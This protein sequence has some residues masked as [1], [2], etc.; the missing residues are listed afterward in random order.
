MLYDYLPER[1]ILYFGD[2]KYVVE[3]NNGK[4]YILQRYASEK[5]IYSGDRWD[6]SR[7]LSNEKKIVK[8][9]R[10][11]DINLQQKRLILYQK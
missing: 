9:F 7:Y 10:Q 5:Y 8:R 6:V 1:D 2:V 4:G 11:H 3:L